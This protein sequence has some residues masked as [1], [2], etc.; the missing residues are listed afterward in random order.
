M[1]WYFTVLKKYAVF[2]GRARRK[3]YWMFILFH[4]IF[5]VVAVFLDKILGNAIEEFGYAYITILY[6]LVLF[7]PELAVSVRRLH[8]TG[9]SGFMI[10]V[11]F[12]P[13]IGTV[14]LFILMLLEGNSGDNKYGP[15][16]TAA[17]ATS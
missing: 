13:V 8:D 7:I 17:A 14:W 16:P 12:I 2:S 10:F 9:R 5:T 6:V 3:E 4:M 11:A 1:S 15:D